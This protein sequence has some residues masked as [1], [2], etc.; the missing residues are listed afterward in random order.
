MKVLKGEFEKNECE[1]LFSKP[2]FGSDTVG[3]T[4]ILVLKRNTISVSGTV[5]IK[6][7]FISNKSGTKK[8]QA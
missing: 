4:V 7:I 2:I 8:D 1:S 5:N 6:N 3:T